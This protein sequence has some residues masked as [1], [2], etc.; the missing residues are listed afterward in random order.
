MGMALL[1]SQAVM[2]AT[3][4]KSPARKSPI[5]VRAV[6]FVMYCTKD[7]RKTRGFYQRLFGL[8]KGHEWNNF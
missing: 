5:A 8:K 1:G 3:K 7:M 6:D 2:P 4:R